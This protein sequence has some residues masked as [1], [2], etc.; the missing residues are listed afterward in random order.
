MNAFKQFSTDRPMPVTIAS[1]FVLSITAW[2]G[3]RACRALIDWDVLSRF[4]GNPVYIFLTGLAWF[5]GGLVLFLIIFYRQPSSL[6]AGSILSMIYMLWYWFDR[7]VIQSSPTSN[8]IFS[9]IAS[10]VLL[11]IFNA[12]LFWPSS[13]AFFTSAGQPDSGS[14]GTRRQDE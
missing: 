3:I 13:Q 10:I 11:V 8:I 5:I 7:T 14:P 4:N 6:Y 12:V 2:S 1:V 9:V